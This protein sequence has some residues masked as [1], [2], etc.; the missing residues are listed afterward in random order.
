MS[1]ARPQINL[2]R[3]PLSSTIHS[4]F[5]SSRACSRASFELSKMVL[6]TRLFKLLL[7]SRKSLLGPCSW[8]VFGDTSAS[9]HSTTSLPIV[10][11][12]MFSI[13]FLK[14]PP[15]TNS[16]ISRSKTVALMKTC[17]SQIT[18]SQ[19]FR[20]MTSLTKTATL[21]SLLRLCTK[22]ALAW[23]QSV[24]VATIS[25]KGTMKL[26]HRRR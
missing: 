18:C 9:V 24:P 2:K 11:T 1:G 14:R 4:T 7:S 15:G 25:S 5:V 6:N 3:R 20:E 12:R 13:A 23:K 16:G 26:I 22:R 19:T 17:L 21:L 10:T 8:S